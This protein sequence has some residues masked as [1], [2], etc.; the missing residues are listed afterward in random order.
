M[1]LTELYK[2][3]FGRKFMFASLIMVALG[4]PVSSF[5]VSLGTSLL[6]LNFLVEGG[7]SEKAARFKSTKAVWLFLLLP[8]IHLLWLLN[9]SDFDFAGHHLSIKIPILIFPLV[10]GLSEKLSSKQIQIL[11]LSFVFATFCGTVVILAILTG[12]FPYDYT[13]IRD[14]SIFVSHIRF[15]LMMVFSIVIVAYYSILYFNRIS[16]FDKVGI[17]LLLLWFII[18][19]II[20]QSTTS[21]VIGILLS[22]GL[23]FIYYNRISRKLLR[24]I[25]GVFVFV[26]LLFSLSLL[27][28]AVYNFHF[29]KS[30]DL[31]TLPKRTKLGNLYVNDLKS[32]GNENGHPLFVL[33]N[34]DELEEAWNKIS[35]VN[36]NSI[37]EN[38]NHI[39]VALI[40]YLTSMG[41]TKDAEGV[42]KLSER[43]ISNIEKGFTSIVYG[44]KFIPYIK[45]Y[46]LIWELSNYYIVGDPNGKSLAQR[47]EYLKVS[48]LLVKENFWFGVG[49]GDL[50]LEFHAMY[51]KI[52]SRLSK[53]N[54]HRAHNQ[55]LTFLI[56]FGILGFL[57][58]LLAMFGPFLI[59]SYKDDVLLIS[60]LLIVFMSMLN[61]D[62][63]ETQAGVTFYVFFYSL[64]IFRKYYNGKA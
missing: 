3:V 31:K 54:R 2:I 24:R 21:W 57:L 42:S 53:E 4:L 51:D 27:S 38:G 59:S 28:V 50:S 62:T 34:Y 25:V 61:E 47:L 13:D 15:G 1:K 58:S 39:R 40:R 20:L 64:L 5:L 60:F 26:I 48:K 41:L 55:Y 29:K 19:I 37:A 63:L 14:V 9:S 33:I 22:I 45:T 16:L 30:V 10:L 12:I 18:F 8:L 32:K 46:E 44:Y 7:W 43:D 49:T 35:G 11:L 36:Y 52:N 17:L 6:I 23:F 56:A